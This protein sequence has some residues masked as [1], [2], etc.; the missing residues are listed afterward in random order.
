MTERL[1]QEGVHEKAVMR[2]GEF[3]DHQ[4]VQK[5]VYADAASGHGPLA[6]AVNAPPDGLLHR[7]RSGQSS[8]WW[9]RDNQYGRIGRRLRPDSFGRQ[10]ALRD[11][12][13]P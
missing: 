5:Y 1:L 6:G 7:F 10:P 11:G 8:S 3:W 13:V 2:A 12:Q 4:L 9:R